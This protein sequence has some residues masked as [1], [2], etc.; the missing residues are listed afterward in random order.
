MRWLS[1]LVRFYVLPSCVRAFTKFLPSPLQNRLIQKYD[2]TVRR[3]VV[4]GRL[5]GWFVFLN[6]FSIIY[7]LDQE[8]IAFGWFYT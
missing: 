1:F 5:V 8:A 7:W 3:G 4:A 2:L 6:F